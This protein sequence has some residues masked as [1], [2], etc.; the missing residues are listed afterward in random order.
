MKASCIGDNSLALLASRINAE[1]TAVASSLRQ[2][3][4]HAMAAGELL[5]EAKALVKHGRWLPWLR[6][7]CEISD[8]TAQL[9]MRGGQEPGPN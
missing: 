5:I 4:R 3:L 1:H 8:R 9:Y 2:G 7:H 6:E